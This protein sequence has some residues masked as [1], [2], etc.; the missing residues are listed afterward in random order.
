[1]IKIGILRVGHQP[2]EHRQR[3]VG[4][5]QFGGLPGGWEACQ[6]FPSCAAHLMAPRHLRTVGIPGRRQLRSQRGCMG[7][8]IAA[9]R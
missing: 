4:L 6:R 8:H 3:I 7:E 9:L 1:M 5:Q 2:E